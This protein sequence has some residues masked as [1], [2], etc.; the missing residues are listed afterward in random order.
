MPRAHHKKIPVS[1]CLI[2]EVIKDEFVPGT[3]LEDGGTIFFVVR[4]K[5]KR[6]NSFFPTNFSS[7]GK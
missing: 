7:W 6:L 1:F 4:V 3:A 5:I 2:I